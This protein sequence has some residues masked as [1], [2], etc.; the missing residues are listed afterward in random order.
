MREKP[1]VVIV[2][3]PTLQGDNGYERLL[4]S[5]KAVISL[6]A[7]ICFFG[8]PEHEFSGEI[9]GSMLMAKLQRF[10]QDTEVYIP[11]LDG[12]HHQHDLVHITAK[13]MFNNTK[14][15]RT[16]GPGETRAKGIEVKPTT[17]ELNKKIEAMSYFK[18][19][20]EL[21][22]TRHYFLSTKEYI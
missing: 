16:Y 3:H 15:Y 21:P 20:M 1:L 13:K 19:Q 5:Y 2:T 12:G 8:I 17:E 18:T 14:E 10:P 7:N 6:G 22:D 4:E 9:G 11:A